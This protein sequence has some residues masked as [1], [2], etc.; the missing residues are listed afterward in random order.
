MMLAVVVIV[1]L[2]AVVMVMA[3][4][5]VVVVLAVVVMAM[6]AKMAMMMSMVMVVAVLAMMVLGRA[7]LVAMMM[8][9]VVVVFVML[10]LSYWLSLMLDCA[11][12]PYFAAFKVDENR[13]IKASS[14]SGI[15]MR[16]QR[17][18]IFTLGKTLSEINSLTYRG[19]TS[20]LCANT[21]RVTALRATG[22]SA[23][24]G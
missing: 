18:P 10:F 3:L 15:G 23:L 24:S 13:P 5:M 14:P 22:V 8:V 21:S 20:H 17:R 6:L 1:T 16:T 9:F 2:A 19:E 12:V 11:Q 4:V 7:T